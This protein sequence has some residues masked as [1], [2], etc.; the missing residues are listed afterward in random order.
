M[1]HDNTNVLRCAA[2][3]VEQDPKHPLFCL[4]LTGTQ[5]LDVTEFS[6]VA[7]GGRDESTTNGSGENKKPAEEINELKSE[8]EAMRRQLAELARERK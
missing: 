1:R 2:L 3:R 6:R 7:R 8:I 4:T 5:L